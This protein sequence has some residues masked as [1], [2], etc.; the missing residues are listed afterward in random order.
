M[1]ELTPLLEKLADKLGTTVE[2]L[3]GGSVESGTSTS[4]NMRNLAKRSI[5][6]VW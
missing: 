2:H 4:A 5:V 6:F 1:K 3:W